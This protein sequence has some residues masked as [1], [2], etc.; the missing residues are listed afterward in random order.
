MIRK[1]YLENTKGVIFNFNYHSGILLSDVEGLGFEFNLSYL[2]YG[3]LHKTVS[4]DTPLLE[5]SGVLNYLNG[6]ESYD[7]FIDFI[8]QGSENLKLYYET[9][10]I[11]YVYVD[12]V[13]LTK[14]EIKDGILRSD[15]VFNKKSYWIKERQL[16]IDFNDS[17]SGKIY[18]FK[19]DYLYQATKEG[20]TT[21]TVNG[22]FNAATIIE[23]NGSVN[24]PEL[25]AIQNG[26]ITSSLR[27]LLDA[28][29]S[30]VVVSSVPNDRYLKMT[31][32]SFETDIYEFQDFTKDNFIELAPGVNTLEFKS[33]VMEQTQ[34]KI[35]IFEYHL[36]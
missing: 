3:H 32:G 19:Y 20:K 8:N 34:C 30:K 7:K 26:K 31:K 17:V 4:R 5:I 21:I 11:K 10:D 25:I 22:S 12:I 28:K 13:V 29:D 1:F 16:T 35:H 9:T 18:P 24:N 2:K 15:I 33:G 6:Y 14:T 36:G 27:L 23:I